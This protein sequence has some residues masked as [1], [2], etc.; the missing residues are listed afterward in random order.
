[1]ST[2]PARIGAFLRDV[3]PLFTT[4]KP[5]SFDPVQ[6]TF[7]QKLV[8]ES[9]LKANVTIRKEDFFKGIVYLDYFAEVVAGRAAIFEDVAVLVE[10]LEKLHDYLDVDLELVVRYSGLYL[11]KD[12]KG[13]Q[14]FRA[15]SLSQLVRRHERTNERPAAGA[16]GAAGDG[17]TDLFHRAVGSFLCDLVV[18]PETQACLASFQGRNDL[19]AALLADAVLAALSPAEADPEAVAALAAGD[20]VKA[21]TGLLA[22]LV[23]A[24]AGWS[25]KTYVERLHARMKG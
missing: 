21:C 2:L 24:S 18:R 13:E 9:A 6:T 1:M 19:R 23:R 25:L 11:I 22:A 3:P 20:V 17:E 8:R 7:L 16:P 15:G 5:V 12:L 10:E 4:E 14:H